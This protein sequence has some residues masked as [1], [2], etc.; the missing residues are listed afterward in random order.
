VKRNAASCEATDLFTNR[1]IFQPQQGIAMQGLDGYLSGQASRHQAFIDASDE[2]DCLRDE[3][4]LIADGDFKDAAKSCDMASPMPG[5]E[6]P[7]Y[8][9]KGANLTRV[10][11]REMTLGEVT[12]DF[13]D[14][15]ERSDRVLRALYLCAAQGNKEA[16]D[17]INEIQ[18][19]Y[20]NDRVNTELEQM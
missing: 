14:N 8:E 1:S 9:R 18:Q 4:E 6:M 7:V 10:G 11:T 13:M 12:Y 20:V 3:L 19:A 17:V 2:M 5:T 16:I 15:A